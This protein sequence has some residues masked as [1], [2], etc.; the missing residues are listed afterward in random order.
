MKSVSFHGRPCPKVNF[1]DMNRMKAPTI[2]QTYTEWT[3]PTAQRISIDT[4]NCT[5]DIGRHTHGVHTFV[6]WPGEGFHGHRRAPKT[7]SFI[8]KTRQTSGT[9]ATNA[10]SGD[11]SGKD[12]LISLACLVEVVILHISYLKVVPLS[13]LETNKWRWLWH[14]PLIIAETQD[15]QERW[16]WQYGG[17]WCTPSM[18]HLELFF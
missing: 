16:C 11:T 3:N 14:K 10:L 15:P 17:T 12:S 13:T 4:R 1:I 6:V 8:G 5:G 7:H 2:C 9:D 18:V